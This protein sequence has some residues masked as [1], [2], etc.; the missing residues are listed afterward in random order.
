MNSLPP[1]GPRAVG[2]A[3]C[4]VVWSSFAVVFLLLIGSMLA[5]QPLYVKGIESPA[6]AS[7]GCFAAAWIYGSIIFLSIAT[8]AYDKIR[9]GG[10]VVVTRGAGADAEAAAIAQNKEGRRLRLASS[11]QAWTDDVPSMIE[12]N[13]KPF[14]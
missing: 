4:C 13:D 2:C 3:K 14:I 12:M 7:G 10:P 5:K 1:P 6:L 9:G 8:L 11:K